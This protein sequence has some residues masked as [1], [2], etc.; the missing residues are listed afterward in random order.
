MKTSTAATVAEYILAFFQE[1]RDPITSA[2]L[3]KLLYYVQGWCLALHDTPAFPERIEAWISGPTCTSVQALYEHLRWCPI[4]QEV[5]VPEGLDPTLRAVIDEVLEQYGI[6]NAWHL[7][8][9]TR[10]EPPWIEARQGIS[11]HEESTAEITHESMKR[12]FIA[13]AIAE[14]RS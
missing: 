4:T 8:L 11:S 13:E 9:R 7:Q 14:D 5:H 12:F 10:H 3:Q 6:D 2:K 1:V